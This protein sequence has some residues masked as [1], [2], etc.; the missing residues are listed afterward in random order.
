MPIVPEKLEEFASEYAK[1]MTSIRGRRIQRL[2][3]RE[4]SGVEY[5]LL[6]QI[7]E[8]TSTALGLSLST[9]T[10]CATNGRGKTV[11]VVHWSYGSAVAVEQ[12]YDL[13]KDS[14]P[15]VTSQSISINVLRE[16]TRLRVVAKAVPTK[17]RPFVSQVLQALA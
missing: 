6:A 16:R 13:L 11:S 17:A 12:Q 5:I 14:L 3:K 9:A 1:D 10:I 2:L 15:A 4:F 8:G 7:G